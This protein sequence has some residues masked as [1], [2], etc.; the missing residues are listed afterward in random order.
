MSVLTRGDESEGGGQILRTSLALAALTGQGF[1]I[2]DIRRKRPSPGLQ[3]QHLAA[4]RLAA[5]LCSA[6][7]AG[8][9]IGS[10]RLSFRPGPLRAGG[11]EM[12][13]GTAGSL[14]LLLQAVLLPA[15]AA[16][17]PVVLTLQGGTDV[18]W[19]CPAD[20]LERV[21]LP[22]FR[23][24]GG[25]RQTVV[26]RGF[27]PSGGGRLELVVEPRSEEGEVPPLAGENPAWHRVRR[28][29]RLPAAD[30]TER[31]PLVAVRGVSV[32]AEKL[33]P[34]QVAERQKKA[35][36][37][38]LARAGLELPVSIDVDYGPSLSPGSALVLWAEG[39]AGGWPLRLG[40]DH[41]GERGVPAEEVGRRAAAL[42]L[43]RMAQ[44]APVEEHLADNLVPL[45]GLAGGAMRC[46]VVSDHTRA[47]IYVVEQF[48]GLR[49]RVEGNLI[50]VA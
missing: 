15:L 19:S 7:V 47:N 41:L 39:A 21:I 31:R 17:G 12:D 45:L 50:E 4:V 26:R 1:E 35:A 20:Y 42:L 32:A 46:Q 3:A 30:L 10:C 49:Y 37:E 29:L 40:A 18:R 22:Y 28:R 8:D 44:A 25:V 38:V 43:S 48:S 6:R 23:L 36:Q 14:T 16:P 27:Y 9:E 34:R 11:F 24:L 2:V 33:R 5:R 13:V